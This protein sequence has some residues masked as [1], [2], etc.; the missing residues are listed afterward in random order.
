MKSKAS[1]ALTRAVS[2]TGSTTSSFLIECDEAEARDMLK[3]VAR[4]PNLA[5][6]VLDAFREANV[7]L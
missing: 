4:Y 7:A 3:H 6:E 1:V 5:R 2:D